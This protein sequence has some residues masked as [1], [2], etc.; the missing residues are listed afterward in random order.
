MPSFADSKIY[1]VMS[2]STGLVYY[3][4]TRKSLTTRF[5]HHLAAYRR[6]NS[7]VSTGFVSVFQVIHYNDAVISLVE[8][9][10]C[11]DNKTLNEREG[12]HIRNNNCVNSNVPG[13]T[14]AERK[15]LSVIA[16]RAFRDRCPTYHKEYYAANKPVRLRVRCECGQSIQSV[17]LTAHR[18]NSRHL[19]NLSNNIHD[20]HHEL[21]HLMVLSITDCEGTDDCQGCEG[22][23]ERSSDISNDETEGDGNETDS[24]DETESDNA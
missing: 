7:G 4:S 16:N 17:N 21:L 6:Y 8:N 14:V 3:G 5:S 10:P 20:C 13:R 2:P 24:N 11:A 19:K 15:A 18:N 9:Y 22:C 1:K 12:W 23:D